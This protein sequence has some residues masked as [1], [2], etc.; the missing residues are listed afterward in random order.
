MRDSILSVVLAVVIMGCGTAVPSVEE[1][2]P[3]QRP[4][5]PASRAQ[6]ISEEIHGV[7]VHDPYRWLE[8]D[9]SEEVVK[10]QSA[11]TAIAREYLDSIPGRDG[12]RKRIAE[13]FQVAVDDPPTHKGKYYFQTKRAAD[14]DQPVLYASEGF[15]AE[16]RVLVN[17]NSLGEGDNTVALDWWYPSWDGT[18]LAYGLSSSGS[19]RSTLHIIETATGEVL[20]DEIPNTRSARVGWL[21]DNSG[22]FYSR[23]PDPDGDEGWFNR[24]FFHKVGTPWEEDPLVYGD[25]GTDEDI[26]APFT[27]PDG[28]RLVVAVYRGA[29]GS[30][31]DLYYRKTDDVKGSF[32]SITAGRDAAFWA[33]VKNEKLVVLTNYKAPRYRVVEIDYD[34]PKESSW[35]E[36][37]PQGEDT[38]D[39]I[40]LIKDHMIVKVM[41]H[42]VVKLYLHDAKGERISEIELP[43]QGRA[44]G[45]TGGFEDEEFYY[46]FTSF[47]FAGDIYR[48]K[49]KGAPELLSRVKVPVN[50]DDYKVKQVFFKSKDGTTVPMFVAHTAGLDVTSPRPT[51]L[52]GYGG[53]NIALTPYFLSRYL[54]FIDAGGIFVMPNLRGGSEYGEQWH[55]DGMLENKQNTFDDFIFAAKYLVD[56]GVTTPSQLAIRG[57]SNG[58]LL[59]GAVM[60][61]QPELYEAVVCNVPLLDMIRYHKFLIAK[62]WIPEYGSSDDP[63]QFKYLREYSP[64]HNVKEG[65]DYPALL[66]MTA[67][68]D[69]RVAPL[70]ARKFAAMIQTRTAGTRPALLHVE[71]QAGHGKGKPISAR[72]DDTTDVMVF[73]MARLGLL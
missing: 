14:Q 37:V 51:L 70:H 1:P 68:S 73:I 54:P 19:E 44:Y 46:G 61:Q 43:A 2:S 58:G 35:R 49:L 40:L 72:V 57:G 3:E 22:F 20:A 16:Q 64:Y 21:A 45:L 9:K 13:V 63:E 29:G 52:Y 69:S 18:L 53:F 65:V 11:Q 23:R 17:P 38:I 10:W 30:V 56:K 66:L 41:E 34:A 28:K 33:D 55:R 50:P 12:V 47:F 6:T 31:A 36:I 71:S 42:A 39:Q 27:S 8:D 67:E 48:Y 15:P 59:V 25:K 7:T 62:L 4:E 24:V 60:V 26:H 32:I 5:Y